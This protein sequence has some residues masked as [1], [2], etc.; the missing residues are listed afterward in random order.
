MIGISIGKAQDIHFSH[1]F[2]APLNT[3]P[4]LTGHFDGKYRIGGNYKNQ[5]QSITRPY[6]TFSGYGDMKLMES[7]NGNSLN[8]G[9]LILNDGSGDGDLTV[10][11]IFGSLAYQIAFDAPFKV[12]AGIGGGY[13]QKSLDFSK[14][15][16]NNQW[17]GTG[18]DLDLTAEL[19]G[20]QKL[21]YFDLQ[22]GVVVD[23]QLS[24]DHSIFAGFNYAHTLTPDE[25]FYAFS[26]NELGS[27]PVIHGGGRLKFNDIYVEPAF[28]YMNQ[29][30]ASEFLGG[31]NVGLDLKKEKP[32][33]I[34]A[35]FFMRASGDAI[36][37]GGIQY[38]NI[39]AMLSYDINFSTLKPASENR[40]GIELSIQYIGIITKAEH[41]LI[42]P[43]IRF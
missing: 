29:K 42:I 39:R 18:Y 16:F 32:T 28:I 31:G 10:R 22:A 35:G 4:A 2:A 13:V 1:F 19:S 17:T 33:I 8:G 20:T 41:G 24:D 3:N 30:K 38:N 37:V 23:Y 11:K 15:Y 7:R 40:G 5:W 14:L 26:A 43:C 9:I 34:W 21:N 27:R 12:T 36:P 25:S 6:R